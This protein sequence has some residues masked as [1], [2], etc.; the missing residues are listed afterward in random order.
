MVPSGINS[1]LFGSHF[2][3]QSKSQ[4][5]QRTRLDL[6]GGGSENRTVDSTEW[7]I[8]EVRATERK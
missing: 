8:E 5:S 3:D 1:Y 6:S 2:I 7:S 4:E